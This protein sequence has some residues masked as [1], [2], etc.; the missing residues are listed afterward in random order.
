MP[1]ATASHVT[2]PPAISVRRFGISAAASA[3]L[4]HPPIPT[5]S[6]RFRF[7]CCGLP[8]LPVPFWRKKRAMT[9]ARSNTAD[10]AVRSWCG[11]GPG[12]V[13]AGSRMGDLGPCNGRAASLARRHE[14]AR[15]EAFLR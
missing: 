10:T 4:R 11:E 2:V 5:S 12:E 13:I 3:S 15:S 1:P 9:P 6:T 14:S 8:V 7:A